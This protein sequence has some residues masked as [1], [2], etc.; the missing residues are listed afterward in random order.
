MIRRLPWLALLVLGASCDSG[1][2]VSTSSPSGSVT[3]K[4]KRI[5]V[6][7][8]LTEKER[9]H[10]IRGLPAAAEG[11]GTLL[12]WPRERFMKLEPENA[13]ASFDVAFLDRAGRVT[14][15]AFL[16]AGD[17][18]GLMPA[19]ES[20]YVLL[21][22]PKALAGVAKGDVAELSADVKA[23]QPK[24]LTTM[25]I[26]EHTVYVELALTE[27]ERQHGLMFRPRM[28]AEDGMLFGYDYEGRR[29][30]WMGN[31]LI[32]LDLAFI[33]A[34]GTIV[35]VNETPTYPNPE[36]PPTPYPTSDSKGEARFVLEM[37]L[38]WFKRKGLVDESGYP[39]PG[40]KAVLPPEALRGSE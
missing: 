14:E 4:G 37:N 8:V 27:S 20:A 40:V 33:K 36:H 19:I 18:R 34:D 23:A 39:K 21:V 13:R 1:R 26:G 38:G 12:A 25:K 22:A 28:S 31:T 11:K 7:L 5:D 6:Q 17:R 16:E 35:N 9:K 2:S 15:V 10:V 32:P 30:F 29:S 3:L 24:D